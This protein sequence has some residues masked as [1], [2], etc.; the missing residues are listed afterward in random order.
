MSFLV[1][2]LLILC[3]GRLISMFYVIWAPLTSNFQL[4]L[5]NEMVEDGR[6]LEDERNDQDINLLSP[7]LPCCG[8]GSGWVFA[9]TAIFPR[10]PACTWL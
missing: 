8:F 9:S 10:C 6:R 2:S 3:R 4:G 1:Y 5:I 7:F